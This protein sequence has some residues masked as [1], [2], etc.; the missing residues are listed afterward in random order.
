MGL[1]GQVKETAVWEEKA[2]RARGVDGRESGVGGAWE[3]GMSQ[4]YNGS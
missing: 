2:L 4:G 1:H 3:F